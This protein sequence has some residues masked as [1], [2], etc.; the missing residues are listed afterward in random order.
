MTTSSIAVLTE[1][2][3]GQAAAWDKDLFVTAPLDAVGARTI[4]LLVPRGAWLRLIFAGEWKG[5][6]DLE[7]SIDR[8]AWT[9]V[10]GRAGNVDGFVLNDAPKAMYYRIRMAAHLSGSLQATLMREEFP[11]VEFDLSREEIRARRHPHSGWI[12]VAAGEFFRIGSNGAP[13]MSPDA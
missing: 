12:E 11:N 10:D 2:L 6:A 1:A 13:G 8:E 3:R 4:P 5:A 9:R 7:R